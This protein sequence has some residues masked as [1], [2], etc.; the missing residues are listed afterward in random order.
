MNEEYNNYEVK[1]K[2]KLPKILIIIMFII[3]LGAIVF[4]LNDK[5]EW[6]KLGKKSTENKT[7]EKT[8]KKKSKEKTKFSIP[9]DA[10]VG[11]VALKSNT[12][13]ELTNIIGKKKNDLV[14]YE[15]NKDIIVSLKFNDDIEYVK[16]KKQGDMN[17]PIYQENNITLSINGNVISNISYNYEKG[18]SNNTNENIVLYKLGK[19]IFVGENQPSMSNDAMDVDYVTFGAFSVYNTETKEVEKIDNLTKLNVKETDDLEPV[20]IYIKNN[21]LYIDGERKRIGEGGNY[22]YLVDGIHYSCYYSNPKENIQLMSKLNKNT[23]ISETYIFSTTNGNL[24]FNNPK[25]INKI[26]ADKICE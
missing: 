25:I 11:K 9:K 22:T 10:K 8:E 6:I 2:S 20:Q 4:L 5:Y 17:M 23:V 3:M 7:E 26:T 15:I 13:Y 14:Y 18:D 19:Y 21:S 24:D 12:Y 16:Y 1:K